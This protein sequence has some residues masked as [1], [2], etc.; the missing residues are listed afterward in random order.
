M[1]GASWRVRAARSE[2]TTARTGRAA[3]GPAASFR[4]KRRPRWPL[5]P[6]MRMRPASAANAC[7]LVARSSSGLAWNPE[8]REQSQEGREHSIDRIALT[9]DRRR[10]FNGAMRRTVTVVSAVALVIYLCAASC[11]GR[12]E[13]AGPA[14]EDVVLAGGIPGTLFLP[15]P[16]EGGAAFLDSPPRPE[17]PPPRC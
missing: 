10:G 11:L 5:A 12:L 7:T 2:R 9:S 15:E 6:V 3:P 16:S 17:R 1:S 8:G 4:I 14:H 13:R